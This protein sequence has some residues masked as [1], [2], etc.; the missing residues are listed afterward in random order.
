[1][2]RKSSSKREDDA[3]E[4]KITEAMS[5]SRPKEVGARHKWRSC[6]NLDSQVI[7]PQERMEIMGPDDLSVKEVG[8]HVCMIFIE[9][10][11]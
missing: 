6:S 4:R 3:G 8:N 5:L 2:L 11:S 9:C 1:M 10:S 7:H